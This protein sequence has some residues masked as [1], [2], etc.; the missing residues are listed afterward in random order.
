MES[1]H[2]VWILLS[3]H[4]TLQITHRDPEAFPYRVFLATP[5]FLCQ[6]CHLHFHTGASKRTL[7]TGRNWGKS[8]KTDAELQEHW[9]GSYLTKKARHS[10]SPRI[11]AYCIKW[12]KHGSALYIYKK[13]VTLKTYKICYCHSLNSIQYLVFCLY[14][15][16]QSNKTTI[17][18]NTPSDTP[19]QNL[20]IT[21]LS[22]P[23][24]PAQHRKL[25]HPIWSSLQSGYTSHPLSVLWPLLPFLEVPWKVQNVSPSR[26]AFLRK[27]HSSN[28]LSWCWPNLIIICWTIFFFC[29]TLWW[30][31]GESTIPTLV[32]NISHRI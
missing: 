17:L 16:L 1:R 21:L 25:L 26:M 10:S 30:P 2:G 28:F 19:S 29:Y 9:L 11:P 12:D 23:S 32:G 4:Q 31:H 14:T 7:G 22:A 8:L 15:A 3:H 5:S 13:S 24:L 20:S 6:G 18:C 27:E